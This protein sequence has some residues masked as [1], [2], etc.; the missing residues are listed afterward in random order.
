MSAQ[1]VFGKEYRRVFSYFPINLDPAK[2]EDI[3]SVHL[4]VQ[5]ADGL[6]KYDGS[7]LRPAIAERWEI[8]RNGKEYTFHLNPNAKFSNGQKI[9]PDD[10][11]AAFSH[12]LKK[13]SI[14]WKDISI[15]VGADDF[16]SGKAASVTGLKKVATDKIKVTI[17]K[18]FPPFLDMLAS[19][20]F[21][22]LPIASL[23]VLSKNHI[24]PFISSGPYILNRIDDDK[25]IYLSKNPFYYDRNLVFFDSVIFSLIPNESDAVRGFIDGRFHDIWPY[26]AND[27]PDS[28]SKTITS[29]PSFTAFTYYLQFN[30]KRPDVSNI[31]LRRFITKHLNVDGFIAARGLPAHYRAYGLIPRGV[32]GYREEP[33]PLD[34]EKDDVLLKKTNCTIARPCKIELLYATKSENELEILL[35]PLQAF[36]KYIEITPK[37]LDPKDWYNRFVATNYS[38]ILL[39]NNPG[40]YDTYMFLRYLL[41]DSY[42]PGIDRK[43]ISKLLDKALLTDDKRGRN[44]IYSQ[45]DDILVEQAGIIPL[46]HGERPS[47]QV[48]KDMTG[49]YI[50]ILGYPYLKIMNLRESDANKP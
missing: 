50:S 37:R 7:L 49:Y 21:V 19:A 44:K 42:H 9:T 11:I 25:T 24:C 17:K 36:S 10:I 18:P 31:Y 38:M 28:F 27:L 22:I 32:L 40:Y 4:I 35:K 14:A 20:N 5:T 12:V 48:R 16:H 43:K 3:N 15:I 2:V 33:R 41:D 1:V 6:V 13:E 46:Y 45:I 26:V 29:I 39:S 30:L 34:S 23:D 47:R 8:S